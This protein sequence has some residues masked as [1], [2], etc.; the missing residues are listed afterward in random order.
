MKEVIT[1]IEQDKSLFSSAIVSAKK[2]KEV[3]V[4]KYD[5]I[6]GK[7]YVYRSFDLPDGAF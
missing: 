4:E 7:L 3:P 2:S 1:A 6:N 5:L